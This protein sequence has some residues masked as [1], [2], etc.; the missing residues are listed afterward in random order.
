M[1]AWSFNAPKP[2]TATSTIR[3]A[4]GQT[5]YTGTL[6][7]SAGAKVFEWDGRGNNGTQWPDGNYTMPITGK[8]TSGQNVAIASEIEGMVDSVGLTK[9]PPEMMVGGQPFTLDKIK[10]VVRPRA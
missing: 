5:V 8:D 1:A 10:R 4:S 3:N 2:V 7:V 9:T 6:P